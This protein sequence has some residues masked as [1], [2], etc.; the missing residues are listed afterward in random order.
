MSF[1]DDGLR[2]LCTTRSLLRARFGETSVIVERRLLTLADARVLR[3]VTI[4][5]PDR[6]RLEP[7]L[8]RLVGSVCVRDAGRIYFKA[9]SLVVERETVFDE[10]DHI[11]IFAVGRRDS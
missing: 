7:G 4:R 8:G 10:V 6:R 1:S 9:H 5:P 2:K 3:D 11:E